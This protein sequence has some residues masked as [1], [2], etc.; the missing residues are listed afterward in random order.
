MSQQFPSSVM[1]FWLMRQ[2]NR[3]ILKMMKVLMYTLYL[4]VNNH[5]NV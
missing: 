5:D 3:L 1:L 4:N 2:D